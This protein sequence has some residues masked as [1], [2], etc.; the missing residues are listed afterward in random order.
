MILN[1]L[2]IETPNL[3]K[4]ELR[5]L[6]LSTMKRPIRILDI[7]GGRG[8]VWTE[9][10]ESGW[11][12]AKDIRLE[13]TIL[14]STETVDKYTSKN[15]SI[16]WKEGVAPGCLESEVAGSVDFVTALDVIEHLPKHEGYQL[17]YQIHRISSHSFLRTPNGFVWQPPFSSNAFQAH[18]SSWTPRE[19]RKMGWRYQYGEAGPK[20]LIGIGARP[21]YMLSLSPIRKT[22]SFFERGLIFIFRATLLRFPSWSFEFVAIRRVR[23]FDLESYA[24]SQN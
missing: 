19:L 6:A 21:R 5:Q 1:N 17:L 24:T 14:D 9:I 10:D 13:V 2:V 12:V 8:R 11:L 7:G 4:A 15:L 23:N 18:V 22:L 3:I 20:F 16:N